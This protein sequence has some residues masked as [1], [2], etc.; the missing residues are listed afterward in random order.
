MD[1]RAK[2]LRCGMSSASIAALLVLLLAATGCTG[3]ESQNA[4]SA[5]KAVK[6]VSGTL[7]DLSPEELFREA[8]VVVEARVGE[9]VGPLVVDM[10]SGDDR[11]RGS[12]EPWVYT[13]R[14]VVPT[15]VYKTD[16]T[17]TTGK[18]VIVALRGGQTDDVAVEWDAEAELAL[19]EKVL[20]YLGKTDGP[21]TEAP[22]RYFTHQLLVGKYRIDE[23]T[24]MA[25]SKDSRRS[26]KLV[27]PRTK[28]K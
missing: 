5:P 14:T 6:K 18:P 4:D 10:P 17:I 7:L 21:G 16:E 22:G 19:G 11:V 20:L 8:P 1:T 15:K 3:A 25:V 13:Q 26:M 12:S 2:I 24:G 9:L 27:E 28:L 23:K